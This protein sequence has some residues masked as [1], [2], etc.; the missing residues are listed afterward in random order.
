VRR[1]PL[2][3]SCSGGLFAAVARPDLATTDRGGFLGTA[4]AEVAWRR[5][6]G[7]DFGAPLFGGGALEV[8]RLF[9]GTGRHG[10]GSV[11]VRGAKIDARTTQSP[12][13]RGASP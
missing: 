8:P 7:E 3:S 1:S 6:G 2:G 4:G 9:D 10:L 13:N 12:T 5:L 11:L